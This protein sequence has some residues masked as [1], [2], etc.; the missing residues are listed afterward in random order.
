MARTSSVTPSHRGRHWSIHAR[1]WSHIGPPLRPSAEDVTVVMT[2]VRDWIQ[3]ND[4]SVSTLLILGVTPELCTLPT[5]AIDRII[6]VDSSAEMISAIWPGRI[7]LQD[8]A[9][10]ADWQQIPLADGA[11]DLAAADGSFALLQFPGGYARVLAEL[12][13]LLRRD[14]RCIVRCFA[15]AETP[16]SVSDVFDALRRGLIGS[17][18]V[19]KWRLAMALQEGAATGVVLARVWEALHAEWPSLE[20]LAGQFQWPIADVR[21]IDAYRNVGRTYCFPTLVEHCEAFSESGFSVVSIVTPSYE[22]GNRCPT[23]VLER[24]SPPA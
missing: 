12:Q 9:I 23:V 15:Q 10:R 22:L 24:S 8:S 16:E 11:I 3:A 7:R 18:H 21:T 14:G 19:L 17:F 6:A 1:Q 2:G 4:R 5:Q 13:R 20:A